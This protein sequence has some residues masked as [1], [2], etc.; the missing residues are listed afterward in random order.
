M[1]NVI[2][3]PN[4]TLIKSRINEYFFPQLIHFIYSL[5]RIRSSGG[6]SDSGGGSSSACGNCY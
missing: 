5:N 3:A 1:F 6:G 4:Q 2:D